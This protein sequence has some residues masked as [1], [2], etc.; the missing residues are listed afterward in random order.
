MFTGLPLLIALL[1]FF[2]YLI[3]LRALY[4]SGQFWD[5]PGLSLAVINCLYLQSLYFGQCRTFH[6]GILR[7]PCLSL[8]IVVCLYLF[9]VVCG[10][11]L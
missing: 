11:L 6:Y 2:V 9:G 10:L 3:R 5:E 4:H 8:P 7:S 1:Y